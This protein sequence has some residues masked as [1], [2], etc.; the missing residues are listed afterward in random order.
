MPWH[1]NIQLP[2]Q[3]EMP[4]RI[5]NILHLFLWTLLH[6]WILFLGLIIIH[7]H[8]QTYLIIKRLFHSHLFSPIR[9]ADIICFDILIQQILS[10]QI[11]RISTARRNLQYIL[12]LSNFLHQCHNIFYMI[13]PREHIHRLAPLHPVAMACKIL[14]IPCLGDWIA[15]NIDHTLWRKL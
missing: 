1:T 9:S 3:L 2:N 13:R 10:Q 15:G 11:T 6:F 4:Q 14:Q 5:H 12:S 8:V 7:A